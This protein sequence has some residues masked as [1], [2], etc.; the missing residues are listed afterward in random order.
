MKNRGQSPIPFGKLALLLALALTPS[1]VPGQGGGIGYSSVAEALEA[2]K[3]KSG[4]N[5]TVQQ[6]W[7]IVDDRPGNAFWSFTPPG[8]PAHPAAIKRSIVS[9]DGGMYVDMSALCQAEKAACDK[10]IEEFKALNERMRSDIRPPQIA[11]S[12]SASNKDSGWRPTRA[13]IDQVQKQSYAYFSAKDG[14]KYQDAYSMTSASLQQLSPFEQWSAIADHTK[15]KVGAVLWRNLRR[16]TWYKDTPQGP[17]VFAAVDFNSQFANTEV[18]C[19][20]VAWQEQPDGSFALVREE[21]NFIESAQ[22]R[23]MKREDFE[24]IR[25]QFGC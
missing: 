12:V 8:H 17:G 18:H 4:A 21:E 9:R 13:Q 19:G 25:S 2:L 20:F 5:V 22:A 7:T 11:V 1:V 15:A 23:S 24:R 3:A 16:I 6:G 14:G 10:L